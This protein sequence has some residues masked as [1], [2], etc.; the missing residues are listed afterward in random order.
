M[1][2]WIDW[3]EELRQSDAYKEFTERLH[4]SGI[5]NRLR[6]FFIVVIREIIFYLI[7]RLSQ[8][9]LTSF[10]CLGPGVLRPSIT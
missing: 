8:M 9:T 1:Q 7:G 5:G 3:A 2:A 10:C 4:S 6:Y